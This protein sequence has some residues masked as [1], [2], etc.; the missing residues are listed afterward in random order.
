MVVLSCQP[1]AGTVKCRCTN[2]AMLGER[3]N[4][5]LP[6]VVAGAYT[7]SHFRST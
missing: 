1:E 7:R 2:T 5:N 6:G 4:V 3:K